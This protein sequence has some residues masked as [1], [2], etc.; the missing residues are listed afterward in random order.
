MSHQICSTWCLQLPALQII[1]QQQFAAFVLAKT[2]TY[3]SDRL[4]VLLITVVLSRVFCVRTWTA[5]ELVNIHVMQFVKQLSNDE[6][7]ETRKGILNTYVFLTLCAD[8]LQVLEQCNRKNVRD[9]CGSFFWNPWLNDSLYEL[10]TFKIKTVLYKK[11]PFGSNLVW[12]QISIN[13]IVIC[14]SLRKAHENRQRFQCN[15]KAKCPT[16]FA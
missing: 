6:P 13:I 1:K 15:F 14:L 10:C 11:F 5:R 2:Q 8:R 16:S 7:R 3:H 4:T 9:R 12:I